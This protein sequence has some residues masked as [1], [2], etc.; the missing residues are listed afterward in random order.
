MARSKP[1]RSQHGADGRKPLSHITRALSCAV[2]IA[3]LWVSSPAP[4]NADPDSGGADP[5][6]FGGLGCSCAQP[7]PVGGPAQR[8]QLTGGLQQGLAVGQWEPHL[9]SSPAKPPG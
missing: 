5:N 7:A 3:A 1:N 9:A 2:S 8:Q 4:G 6:A